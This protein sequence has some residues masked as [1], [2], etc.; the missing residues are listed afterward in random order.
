MP[1]IETLYLGGLRTE[2][3]HSKS[4]TKILTDAP[5]DNHG[6]GEAFSPT[7]LT[8]TS[9]GSCMLTIIGILAERDHLELTGTH[10]SIT[11]TMSADIPRRIVKIEINAKLESDRE[12]SD[13]EQ[14]KFE[15]AA[16]SC[17]VALSLH[18]DIE[19]FIT[20]QWHVTENKN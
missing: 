8:A 11:K 4:G 20:F 16:R 12:L 17:P 14:D 3:T 7:D 5:V 15:R 13:Y 6:K 18:P 9:L 10:L 1:T 19:Q 2:A